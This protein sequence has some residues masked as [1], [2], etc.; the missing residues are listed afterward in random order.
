MKSL[1]DSRPHLIEEIKAFFVEYNRLRGRK[2]KPLALS[3]PGK[4]RKLIK[5]GMHAFKK[6]NRRSAA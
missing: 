6:R 4:S 5:S 3:G 2:F 1:A